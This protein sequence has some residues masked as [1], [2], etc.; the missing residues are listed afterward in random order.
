MF[1]NPVYYRVRDTLRGEDFYTP[2]CRSL[3][4]RMAELI[5]AGRVA[6]G[7]TLENEFD[8]EWLAEVFDHTP[9]GAEAEDY[10]RQ[11]SDVA[12]RRGLM[13]AA[14]DLQ[15]SAGAGLGSDALEAHEIALEAMR[16]QQASNL[17]VRSAAEDVDDLIASCQADGL[18]RTGIP[19]LDRGFG[20]FERGALSII[21]A[22]PGVGKTAFAVVAAA[23]MAATE[24]I[25]FVSADM[26]SLA[27]SRRL[28]AYL[29]WK[30]GRWTPVVSQM[31]DPAL[32]SDQTREDLRIAFQRPEASRFLMTDRGGLN[33]GDVNAQIRAWKRHCA[34]KGLPPLGAVFVDHIAK[35]A[36]RQRH[37][38]LYE[39]TS[40]ATNELLDV[41]KQHPELSIIALCQLNRDTE[42][43]GRRPMI[44]DL[45]DSGKIEEDASAVLLLHREDHHWEDQAENEALDTETRAKAQ[46]E[47]LRCKG[48]FEVIIGKNRNDR[49]RTVLLR[50]TIGQNVIRDPNAQQEAAA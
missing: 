21:A 34:R 1:H 42:K 22:R 47:L 27:V 10:A 4:E 15:A 25:G 38:S 14:H 26:Q 8:G 44:S 23:N 30:S 29:N 43:S 41:A 48:L 6:D 46:K 11:I 5:D 36:P 16:G 19:A 50:H 31:K 17:E 9:S 12:L 39:K 40:F 28:A 33:V 35:I 18:L 32:I 24:T 2:E 3:Y 37:G 7:V 45:R 49:K 13:G 20:G